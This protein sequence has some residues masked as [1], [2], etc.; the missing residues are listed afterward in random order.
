MPC[1]GNPVYLEAVGGT[2]RF[3]TS[4]TDGTLQYLG[5]DGKRTSA[6]LDRSYRPEHTFLQQGGILLLGDSQ[7]VDLYDQD[8]DVLQK[9]DGSLQG[10]AVLDNGYA[11]YKEG[12]RLH[13]RSVTDGSEYAGFPVAADG[14]FLYNAKGWGYANKNLLHIVVF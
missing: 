1:S 8:G 12:G 11:A 13:L 9:W 7:S 4:G 6:A 10:K 3:I 2:R 14:P 5:T